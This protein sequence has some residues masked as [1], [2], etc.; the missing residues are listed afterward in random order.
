[1]HI[2]TKKIEV[3]FQPAP[4]N[5]YH[6]AQISL[7]RQTL[8]AVETFTY[9]GSTLSR[10]ANIDAEINNRISKVGSTFERLRVNVWKRRGIGIENKLKV[11][12]AV[13][14]TT[15]LYGSETW[16]A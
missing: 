16:T 1:M 9:L 11:Y 12:W 7:N 8:Q 6:E 3:T 10:D 14:I 5:R 2:S 13:V 4:G 15:L